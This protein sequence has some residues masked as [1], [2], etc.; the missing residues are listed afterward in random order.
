MKKR[1]DDYDQAPLRKTEI[2][3]G[4]RSTPKNLD[5]YDRDP[6]PSI[7]ERYEPSIEDRDQ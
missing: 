5:I 2:S 1:R 7:G 6:D 3:K 4:R